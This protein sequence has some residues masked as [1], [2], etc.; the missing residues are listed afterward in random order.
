MK[1]PGKSLEAWIRRIRPHLR[2][3][4]RKAYRQL[5]DRGMSQ[6]KPGEPIVCLDFADPAIDAVGGRYYFSLVLD[7]IDAGYFPVFTAHRGTVSTFG[8][9]KAKAPLLGKR[10][11]TVPSSGAIT[12][13]FFLITDS[14]TA[15]PAHATKI[16]RVDYSHR[17][18]S[19]PGEIPFPVFVHPQIAIKGQLP[20]AYDPQAARPARIFFGG[21]TSQGKYDKNVI[22][23]V[24]GMFTRREMLE[25]VCAE[26]GE[27]AI[28]RPK[29]AEEWLASDA[30]HPFVLCETQFCKIPP[31]RWLEALSKGDFFLACPGVGM[32]L[33]HNLIESMATGS[34]PVL[35]YSRYLTPML[36]DG[37]NCLT[38]HDAAS[39]EN[40]VSRVL[41]MSPEEISSLRTGTKAYYDE[42][43]APGRFT[44]R[45]L[46]DPSPDTT[47]LMNAYRVPR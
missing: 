22:G 6:R 34:V 38:F 15:A 2:P 42:F 39:L 47:L 36:E 19:A 31:D 13:P 26:A 17:I 14:P 16:V 44:H 32:P 18:Q 45:L 24:Y 4:Y 33:C 27:A 29:N 12:E 8:T 1:S 43:L 35:Q 37:V 11:G 3:S 40:V 25:V 7:L 46:A 28:H 23:E 30:P 20:F 21:N 10:L 9:Y 41:A 5:L